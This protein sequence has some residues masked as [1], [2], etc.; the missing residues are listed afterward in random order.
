M[1]NIEII[2]KDKN[3]QEIYDLL[4]ELIK[5]FIDQNHLKKLGIL[6]NKLINNPR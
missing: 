3:D 5:D 6:E 2:S 4:N 1:L